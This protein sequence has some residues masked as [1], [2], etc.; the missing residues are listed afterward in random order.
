MDRPCIEVP[1]D[2]NTR[3]SAEFSRLADLCHQSHI[4]IY[5]LL[6]HMAASGHT[7][8]TLIFSIPFLFPIPMPG[9]SFFFG[10]VITFSGI[11]IALKKKAWLPKRLLD[12]SIPTHWLGKTFSFGAKISKK[13]E[14]F[15][16]PRGHFLIDHPGIIQLN[17]VIIA[18]SGILLALPLPPGTNLPPASVIFLLSLGT[19]ER[20]IVFIILGY[21]SFILNLIFFSALFFFGVN[22]IMMIWPF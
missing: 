17:G 8:L 18:I 15:I 9:L 10:T 21:I 11:S 4:T 22:G 3:L 19:L 6:E 2:S 20:D 14:R 5:S 13:L 7:L 1:I 16:K 12:R